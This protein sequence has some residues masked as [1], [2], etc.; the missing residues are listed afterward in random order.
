MKK[1]IALSAIICFLQ[2]SQAQQTRI[3]NDPLSTYNLAR[4]YFQKE[5]YS[6]AYPLFRELEMNQREADRS[7]SSINY[8]EVKYYAT[9][10]ALRQNE[11]RAVDLAREFIEIEDNAPK[12][13]LMN[14]HL[15]EYY[16]RQQDFPKAIS[17][18]ENV[19]IDNL[20]NK[21][22][23]DLKFHLGYAYF[24][25]QRF[26][27]AKPL[28]NTIRQLPKDPNYLDANYY[29]GFLSFYEKNYKDALEGF[30]VVEDH[31]N[32]GKVVPYYIATIRY[33]LGEKAQALAYAESKLKNGNQYY[34]LELRQMVGHAY[35]EKKEYARALPFLE[36][37]VN[38]TTKVNRE[39]L[40]ELSYAYY[41]TGNHPKAIEGL[42]QLGGK[43]D[44]LAQN[45]MY[46]L[47]DSYLKTGQKANARNAFLFCSTNSSNSEQKE[48]SM[49]NYAKLSYE[50]GYQDV[51]L[52]EFRKFL[53]TYPQ[54]TYLEEARELL[55]GVM[56]STNNYKD[57]LEVMEGVK[58]ANANTRAAYARILYGRATELINDGMLVTANELL[59]K[60]EK[61]TGNQSVLPYVQFWKGEIAYRLNKTDEAIRY[62]FE[63]LKNPLVNGEVNP[64]HAK[65][66]LGYSFLR[67]ENYRQS[68][69]F[70]EQLFT[71][72]RINSTPIEQDAYTR[73]AD[74]YFMSRDFKKALV[75]YDKVLEFSWPSGDY[76]MFQKGMIAGVNNSKEKIRLLSAISRQYPTSGLIADANL[77]IGNTHLAN[78]QY[79]EAVPFLKTVVTDPNP[80]LK[81]KAYLKLGIAYYN[82]DNNKEALNQYTAL[83]QQFPNSPEAEEA[84]ENAK[85]I[86]VEEGRTNEYVG[87]ARNMGKDISSTQ[88]DQLAY[89]EAEVQ[90]NNGN[91]PAAAKKFEDYLT[92]F[93]DGKHALEALYYKSEIYFNQKD[94]AKAVA[95]YEILSD[96]A[97]HKF[98]ERALLQASRLN[99]FDLKNYEKAEIYFTRLKE[100]A[101]TQ[102]GKME[103]MR[104]LLRSQYQL[105]KWNDA[106]NNAKDLLTQK[107]AGTD[108]KVLANMVIAKSYQINNQCDLAITNYRTVAGLSKSAF[109]AEA[110]YEIASCFFSQERFPDAEKAA[111]EVVNKSGSY[112]DW[113]TKSYLL[114][115]DIY[116]KQKDYFNAKATYQSVVDKAKVED[117]RQEADRKLKQVIEEEKK[118]SK[119]DGK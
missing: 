104:G 25:S 9:V 85:S 72:P 93:P 76:A 43:E 26:D 20:G 79:R 15:A 73:A 23:A 119:V 6:L 71:T 31:P 70:F 111:F 92:R 117:L 64:V 7:S 51:A 42:K 96:R 115:G 86:Y 39:D 21:E 55:V 38:K 113:V 80:S 11:S 68:L 17:G 109:G 116:Y 24:T 63:Y 77:E 99:F 62:L 58:S 112:E 13:Q 18:Y 100:F 19:N 57:A 8:Q 37:Y 88:E 47:A 91:F 34:D 54:S 1:F 16:F 78:E 28:L 33:S 29:Y 97:P 10:C 56:A 45:A 84:L 65:Y 83:L 108:D 94:W 114:L 41:E 27:Q 36:A 101:S 61:E 2:Y 44:S 67:K 60:A 95:G 106:V 107:S 22:I 103:A 59:T 5:Q 50:L 49:F 110:R 90:F 98:A 82:L 4:E 46:L 12:V 14:F 74:C 52:T 35:F 87:F 66:N 75:M 118:Q 89:Q 32:Y 30:S 81:P 69:G 48:V 105:K 40:Y 3:I 53:Q 102:E